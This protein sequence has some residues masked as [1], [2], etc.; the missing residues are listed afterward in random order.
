MVEAIAKKSRAANFFAERRLWS[1]PDLLINPVGTLIGWDGKKWVTQPWIQDFMKELRQRFFPQGDMRTML[2][3]PGWNKDGYWELI[4][5]SSGLTKFY[6]KKDYLWPVPPPISGVLVM[7]YQAYPKGIAPEVYIDCI[8]ERMIN[9]LDVDEPEIAIYWRPSATNIEAM[10]K[11]RI[12]WNDLEMSL[13][14]RPVLFSAQPE[15]VI[16]ALE[17][18]KNPYA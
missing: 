16:S 15:D 18:K 12:A 7:D 5:L 10:A 3:L 17:T 4:L 14:D 9:T 1:S 11:S 8:P 13:I 2:S 6:G